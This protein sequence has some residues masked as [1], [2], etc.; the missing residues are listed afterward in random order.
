MAEITPD[1]LRGL[2]LVDPRFSLENVSTD[3]SYQ[4]AGA[5]PGQPVEE[6]SGE[7]TL[8]A[9]G[10]L[11]A[12]SAVDLR[13]TA[14]KSGTPIG[15]DAGGRFVW[16]NG[17]DTVTQRRGSLSPNKAIGWEHAAYHASNA[18]EM[19]H[20]VT[21]PDHTVVACFSDTT[22]GALKCVSLDPSDDTW[23][24]ITTIDAAVAGP[25]SLVALPSGRIIAVYVR[26]D[27]QAGVQQRFTLGVAHSDDNG[28]TWTIDGQHVPGW[29]VAKSDYDV[30]RGMRAVY[31]DG[32]ITCFVE[33]EIAGGPFIQGWHLVSDDRGASWD[34]IEAFASTPD[35]TDPRSFVPIVRPDGTII[36][37]YAK[38]GDIRYVRKTSPRSSLEGEP[39]WDSALNIT[40]PEVGLPGAVAAC[41]FDDGLWIYSKEDATAGDGFNL[42]SRRRDPDTLAATRTKW[43][44]SRDTTGAVKP[45]D[46]A[47]FGNDESEYIGQLWATPYKAGV[48]LLHNPVANNALTDNVGALYCGGYTSVDWAVHQ[49][50]T[51]RGT[52]GDLTYGIT[53]L[54]S[55][56]PSTITAW[57][58]SGAA[59][60][61]NIERGFEITSSGNAYSVSR[62]GPSGAAAGAPC[63]VWARLAVSSGGALGADKVAIRL[64]RADGTNDYDLSVR[65]TTTAIRVYDNNGSA[66]VGSDVTGLNSGALRDVLIAQDNN[67][68]AVYYK[69]VDDSLWS[70][71]ASGTLTN[72]TSTPA[73]TNQITWGVLDSSGTATA[74]F[75]FVGSCIDSLQDGSGVQ[76]FTN[77]DDLQGRPFST[78]PQWLGDTQGYQIRASGGS[79]ARSDAWKCASRAQYGLYNAMPE[80]NPSRDVDWRTTTAA[81]TQTIEFEPNT[82]SNGDPLATRL[83]SSSI[84][85]YLGG[86]NVRT[87]YLEGRQVGTSTWV[88][89]LTIDQASAT[90]GTGTYTADVD[91]DWIRPASATNAGGRWFQGGELIGG[92]MLLSWSGGGGSSG[93]FE[94]VDNTEGI[95]RDPS[96]TRALEVRVTGDTSAI[97]GTVS[98]LILPPQSV[99]IAHGV[100]SQYDGYRVRLAGGQTVPDSQY[101]IGV[102]GIG[103]CL[104]FSTQYSHGRVVQ[105]EAL[106]EEYAYADGAIRR[107]S[108]NRTRKTVEF[109][110]QEGIVTESLY[111]TD[112]NP[113]Y[114]TARDAAGYDGIGIKADHTY[115]AGLLRRFR[116]SSPV[117]Y[118]PAIEPATGAAPSG[119][120]YAG[121]DLIFGWP[122]LVSS[123]STRFGDEL[124]NE[125]VTLD[126]ISIE[127]IL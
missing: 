107:R 40:A 19:P 74:V 5:E 24:A 56:D 119:L 17:S 78:L 20:A 34:Q 52:S 113:D 2:I 104:L 48:L 122:S 110:W 92:H 37:L 33:M 53:F 124:S 106:V 73:S 9:A 44:A 64:R 49:F 42:C 79:V 91:G 25:G 123:Q 32:F 105:T 121:P 35:G 38:D 27:F 41:V 51:H 112:P 14:W 22:S 54:G 101:R 18:Y 95:W 8:S 87:V 88:T 96:A 126:T 10:E 26:D 97:S 115:A 71:A 65:F 76:S 21:L 125:F 118:W 47:N 82:D 93:S 46:I 66:Q 80:I 6:V 60:T 68:I 86:C 45:N 116:G 99:G 23:S 114:V 75:S 67:A 120:T 127:E 15:G 30:A 43:S 36:V 94:I 102:M 1:I 63:L 16:R 57:T 50:G 70:V 55:H 12:D 62:A 13:V 85:L 39:S 89:L 98:A 29:S 117:V 31:H 7:M 84:G 77:P 61:A 100:T 109:A 3:S 72:D 11:T 59:S 103:P 69:A 111:Q 81:A 90:L 58:T 108:L 28:A 83:L 4:E